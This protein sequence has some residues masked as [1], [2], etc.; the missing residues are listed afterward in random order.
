[1]IKI[2]RIFSIIFVFLSFLLAYSLLIPKTAAA[3]NMVKPILVIPADWEDR[4]SSDTIQNVYIPAILSGMSQAQQFYVAHLG[5]H[6]FNYI[7]EVTVIH[8]KNR[9]NLEGACCATEVLA[10]LNVLPTPPNGEID[11]AFVVGSG[12]KNAAA[13]DNPEMRLQDIA[14]ISHNY[15]EELASNNPKLINYGVGAIAH[16]LG[17]TFG[18]THAGW[19][20]Q[21]PCSTASQNECIKSIQDAVNA[22]TKQYP[23]ASEWSTSV[24]GYGSIPIFPNTGFNNSIWNP[25]VQRIYQN[26]FINPNG[27]P[28]PEPTP[29]SSAASISGISPTQVAAGSTFKILGGGLGTNTGSI[30]LTNPSLSDKDK[31]NLQ[32]QSWTN[33]QITVLVPVS[34]TQNYQT[35]WQLSLILPDGTRLQSP[36]QLTIVPL[37]GVSSPT[38]SPIDTPIPAPTAVPSSG[39]STPPV[40]CGKPCAYASGNSCYAGSCPYGVDCD[41]STCKFVTGCS[42][43]SP[44]ACTYGTNLKSGGKQCVYTNPNDNKCHLGNCKDGSQN[45]GLDN[46]CGYIPGYS[47]DQVVDCTYGSGTKPGGKE[48]VY[49]DPSG[50]YKGNCLDG[51]QNC[52]T[53]NNCGY[54]PAY[55]SG[56]KV[57]CTTLQPAGNSSSSQFQSAAQNTSGQIKISNYQDLRAENAFGDDGSRTQTYNGSTSSTVEWTK[58]TLNPNSPIYVARIN[59]DQTTGT[60]TEVNIS[61]GQTYQVD[62]LTIKAK[63]IKKVVQIRVGDT[64][65]YSNFDQTFKVHL[66]GNGEYTGTYTVPVFVT[67]SDGTLKNFNFTFNYNPAAIQNTGG[68]GSSGGNQGTSGNSGGIGVLSCTGRCSV[69]P[70]GQV[71]G[72]VRYG[73]GSQQGACVALS[74]CPSGQQQ[75]KDNPDAGNNAPTCNYSQSCGSGGTQVCHGK[76]VDGQC[77]FVAGYS[78]CDNCVL[79]KVC[80]PGAY[81]SHC[82][83]R[84]VNGCGEL[85]VRQCSVD[86]SAWG[87]SH[88][89]CSSGCQNYCGSSGGGPSTGPCTY[90]EAIDRSI[91]PS[92]VHV[93]HGTYSNG[94]CKYNPAV[95]PSCSCS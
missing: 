9:T 62:N 8:A 30:S 15:I 38:P 11:I 17:H 6:S 20:N 29:P 5:G 94:S 54:V 86:G 75:C 43:G 90:P 14:A 41:V 58:S 48:C 67:Y 32:I 31:P 24:M 35:T 78:S 57:D 91:C 25:E 88:G 89:E 13:Y 44:V 46:N 36:D 72:T 1:M 4:I 19:G 64:I 79:P 60:V 22:G 74:S 93:C 70:S 71:E 66:P 49:S 65:A 87:S 82:T 7:H 28:A 27:D 81:D 2:S 40:A 47:S 33:T 83:G 51:S 63:L 80:T 3:S 69:C 56:Q 85:E 53:N 73:D 37:G 42:T 10:R 77:R 45:C 61:N 18:L 26:P 16:E 21:H 76:Y 59:A 12:D 55:S 39:P 84:C 34:T 95:D 50:C 23:P 52:S 68:S 92:G